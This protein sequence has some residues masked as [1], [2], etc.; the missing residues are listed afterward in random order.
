M[1]RR[2]LHLADF[3]VVTFESGEDFLSSLESRV[4]ACVIL[5]V[6]LARLSGLDVQS[7]IRATHGRIPVI[8]I[9]ASADPAL[10]AVVTQADGVALLRKPFFSS[11]LIDAVSDALLRK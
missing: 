1:L 6:H 2:V 9:T 10:D 11:E 4:P 3:E 5:D 8:F 7:R